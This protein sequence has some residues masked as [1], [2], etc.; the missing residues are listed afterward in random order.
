MANRS[1]PLTDTP[2]YKLTNGIYRWFMVSILWLLCSLP[3]F[4]IGAATCA[5]L[6]EFSDPD[7]FYS[8][9]LTKDFFH[10]F[11]RCFVQG[12]LVWLMFAGLIG[13]LVVDVTFYQQF[14][15]STGWVL[16]V[17]ALVV[18]NA[19]LGFA[20]FAFFRIVGEE[21]T[22]MKHMLKQAGRQM[23]LCLP[24]WAIMTGI[25]LAVVS[26]LIQMPILMIMLV[27]LPGLYASVHCKLI[28][29]FMRRYEK[30]EE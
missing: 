8:H 7:N 24:V 20:R 29:W 25:D 14:T 9:K 10:R 4:T 12:T 19:L 23:L 17:V 15:G 11:A 28:Q 22:G 27:V 30:E 5:A 16:P 1:T 18:G 26:T 13:L 2:A 21:K 3:V 6:G